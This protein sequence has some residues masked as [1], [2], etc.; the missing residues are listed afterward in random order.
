MRQRPYS[1]LPKALMVWLVA[2]SLLL[3]G[4]AHRPALNADAIAKVE[5]LASMGLSSADL[6]SIPGEDGAKTAGDCPVCHIAA[7]MVLPT[8]IDSLK[9]IELRVAAAILVPAQTRIF[10]RVQNPATPVRAPPLA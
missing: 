3:V 10:G 8:P 7:G 9:K 6:C 2:I 4:F 1:V 5:Y